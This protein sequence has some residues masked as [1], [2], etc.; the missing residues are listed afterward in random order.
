M[1]DELLRKRKEARHLWKANARLMK[2]ELRLERLVNEAGKGDGQSQRAVR[3]C[4]SGRHGS[5]DGECQ[6]SIAGL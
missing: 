6:G 2:R 3:E 5:D 1:R 4:G